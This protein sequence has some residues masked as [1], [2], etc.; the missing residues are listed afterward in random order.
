MDRQDYINTSNNLL[1]QP[2]YRPIPGDP[3]NKIKAKLITMLRKVKNQTGLDNNTYK[4]MYPMGCSAPKF[5]GFPMIHKPDI[6]L[7]LWCPAEDTS[8]MEWLRYLP[9]YLNHW[10][11]GPPPHPLYSGFC[12]TGK[13]SNITTW[14][15]TSVHMNVTALFTTVPVEPTIGHN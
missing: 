15:I 13:Q 14:G 11:V 5:P 3:T 2:A 4:A 12:W 6:P 10:L 8:P 1:A 9:K 7:G